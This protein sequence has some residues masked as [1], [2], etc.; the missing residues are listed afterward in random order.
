MSD[1]KK[2]LVHYLALAALIVGVATVPVHSVHPQFHASKNYS[3][4]NLDE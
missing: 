1:I 2:V 4:V 3:S